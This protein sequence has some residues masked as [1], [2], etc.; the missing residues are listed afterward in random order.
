MMKIIIT[1]LV[2]DEADVIRTMID[3]HMRNGVDQ[4]IIT[5]N[6]SIDGT[7]DIL[8]DYGRSDQ[9]ILLYEPPSDFSQHRWVTRMARMAQEDFNADWVF[10]ADADELFVPL[11]SRSLK[12]IL[13]E[14]DREIQVL[15]IHRQDFV[16]FKRDDSIAP[17]LQMIYKKFR[18]LNLAGKPLPPKV[19]HRPIPGI[20]I[21]QGNHS[22]YAATEPKV[23]ELNEI[24]IY[25]YP[26]RS[27]NQFKSKVANGGSGYSINTELPKGSGFHKRFWYQLLMEGKLENIFYEKYFHSDADIQAGLIDGRLLKDCTIPKT[28]SKS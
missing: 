26:I 9:L 20:K 7:R 3:Y 10:H 23:D 13:S 22:V 25:H 24:S 14:V 19:I 5:D 8:N 12:E 11:G 1:L 17:Q 18:S 21:S 2:R 4:F 15:K 27:Y 28:M 16:P 6:G